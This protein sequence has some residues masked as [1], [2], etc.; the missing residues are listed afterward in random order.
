[1]ALDKAPVRLKKIVM[2]L[3]VLSSMAQRVYVSARR[4]DYIQDRPNFFV[5]WK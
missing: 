2:F 4:V 5:F 1:M 3:L